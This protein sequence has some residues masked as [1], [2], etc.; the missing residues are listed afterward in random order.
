MLNGTDQHMV[1][2]NHPDLNIASGESLTITLRVRPAQFQAR[3]CILSKGSILMPGGR[4]ALSTHGREFAPNLALDVRSS[5]Q[6][7]L[8]SVHAATL[9]AGEWVHVSWVYHSD[10]KTSTVYLN[11]E[12]AATLS[13]PA[14]GSH[15]IGNTSDLLVGCVASDAYSQTKFE[16]WPGDL[17]ELRI[18]KRALTPGEV[19]ADGNSP[20]ANQD[21]LVAAYDFSEVRGTVVPDISGNERHGSLVGFD[22]RFMSVELPVGIGEPDERLAGFCVEGSTFFES[23]KSITVDLSGM[24]SLQDITSLKVFYMG[25]AE[26]L[27]LQTAVL[28]GS[29]T[30]TAPV[31]TI[32]GK[33]DL[34]PGEHFFW[35]TADISHQA[36]EGHSLSARILQVT[37][38]DGSTIHPNHEP[39]KR[40]ILLTHK[41]LF[42]GGDGGAGHYRIPAIITAHDSSL[43]TA[44][45]KRW[46]SADDLPGHIDMVIRRSADH[47][48][49]WSA[50]YTLADG[51]HGIGFSDPVLFLNRNNGMIICLFAG[52]TGFYE[53]TSENPI[54]IYQAVSADHGRS[55]SSPKEI[56]K[57]IYGAESANPATQN[58]QG[59]FVSSGSGVQ[60]STGRLLAVLVVRETTSSNISNFILYSDDDAKTWH[61]GPSRAYFDGN[62]A[63]VAELNNKNLLMSIRKT[64]T[65]MFRL[66]SDQGMTWG[67]PFTQP[68]ITAPS[69]NGDLIRYTSVSDGY[70]K[71]RLLHS[72]PLSTNRENVSV[73]LS[74]NEGNYWSVRKS[75][76]SG[77]SAYSSLT[78][79]HDGTIGVYYEVGEYETYQLYF[80]RFSL[81]WLTDGKDT[82]TGKKILDGIPSEEA[83]IRQSSYL[84]YPNPAEGAVTITGSLSR[85]MRVECYDTQGTLRSRKYID[86][87][88]YEVVFPLQGMVAGLYFLKIGTSTIKLMVR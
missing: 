24:D 5:D 23:L 54:R 55:W 25:S 80:A 68:E 31:T 11:G 37:S 4:Y 50:P 3:Y 14:I 48:Q 34:P 42:S 30:P 67:I 26:R 46:N 21:S 9:L 57:Q 78:I 84:V 71:N 20:W 19:I 52:G 66:S 47:G 29:A 44:T 38:G 60:L 2:P 86:E 8:G 58:W 64:G 17:D 18:W 22:I 40:T 87:P 35:V 39:G 10:E 77:P 83:A 76:Y 81:T 33:V 49:T 61:T 16:F 73:L 88:C 27:N 6:T 63:K 45:D 79:L 43:V 75:L 56:T 85:G 74:Y 69:C 12:L 82:W 62:E 70:D 36:R 59:A 53:S 72:L 15:L 1:I 41:L 7:F 51:G 28:F 65:R 13:E 32:S